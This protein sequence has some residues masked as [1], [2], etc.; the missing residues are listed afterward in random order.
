MTNDWVTPVAIAGG[1]AA[2]GLGAY[3]MFRKKGAEPG[4]D[5]TAK[6]NFTYEGDGGSYIFQVALGAT[7]VGSWFD[8][9]YTFEQ[10]IYV[11]PGDTTA[12]FTFTLPE[13]MNSNTYDAECI[14][15]TPDMGDRDYLIKVVKDSELKVVKPN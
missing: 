10:E 12:E 2:I 11:S 7:I 4:D 6:F 14:I 13:S 8:R 5:I 15:R 9:H 1:V 3:L